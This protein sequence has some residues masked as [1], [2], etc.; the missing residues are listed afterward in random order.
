MLTLSSNNGCSHKYQDE[1]TYNKDDLK[2]LSNDLNILCILVIARYSIIS[3]KN[4]SY[5]KLNLTVSILGVLSS[6]SITI[7]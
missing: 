2:I 4:N 7:K 1:R 3:I 6:L 5:L